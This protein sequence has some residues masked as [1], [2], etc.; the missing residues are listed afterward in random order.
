VTQ[1]QRR[2]DQ[3]YES[4][5]LRTKTIQSLTSSKKGFP[6]ENAESRPSN[7]SANGDEADSENGQAMHVY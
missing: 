1:I 5:E 6:D 7:S 2:G 3:V 4:G